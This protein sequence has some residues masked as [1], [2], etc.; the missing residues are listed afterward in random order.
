MCIVCVCVC[1]VCVCVCMCVCMCAY[2]MCVCC[3]CVYACMYLCVVCAVGE[4][5]V[6]VCVCACVCV[7]VSGEGVSLSRDCLL[8]PPHGDPWAVFV[9]VRNTGESQ[10]STIRIVQ[11]SLDS[12]SVKL[13]WCLQPK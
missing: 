5:C 9:C 8:A 6:C 4:L 12:T 3:M 10:Q 11:R 13:T 7:C 2:V 1:I